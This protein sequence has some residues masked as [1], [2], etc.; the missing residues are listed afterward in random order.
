MV[1]VGRGG[2]S[3]RSALAIIAGAQ[4]AHGPSPAPCAAVKIEAYSCVQDSSSLQPAAPGAG[5]GSGAAAS[6]ASHVKPCG[7]SGLA[8]PWPK[9][10]GLGRN[11]AQS[12]H[13][14]PGFVNW[15]G[16]LSIV[17]SSSLASQ[18]RPYQ[19]P[20]PNGSFGQEQLYLSPCSDGSVVESAHV[21][22]FW[23]GIDAQDDA[24]PAAGSGDGEASAAHVKP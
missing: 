16:F 15:H 19:L 21:P 9:P 4:D 5:S 1:P 23:H 6:A 11:R 20:P 24:A 8:G 10:V 12:T 22:P 3:A 18:F 2:F 7:Q 14:E 17:Q 13:V